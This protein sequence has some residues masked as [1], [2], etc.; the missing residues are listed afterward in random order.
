M[1]GKGD[2]SFAPALETLL[3]SGIVETYSMAAGEF[4]GDG[5]LDLGH[6]RLSV[7]FAGAP[8][9]SGVSQINAAVPA[10]FPKAGTRCT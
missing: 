8:D 10:S 6:R 9:A 1:L 5:K 3:S 2:G 4:T 7:H